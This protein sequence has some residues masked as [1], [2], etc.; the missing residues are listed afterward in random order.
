MSQDKNNQNNSERTDYSSKKDAVERL[1][2]AKNKTYTN[3]QG[4]PGKQYRKGGLLS[5]IPSWIKAVFIKFWFSGAICY[6][7][8]W[9]L[10]NYLWDPLDMIVILGIVAGMVNDIL[11]NNAFRFFAIVPD[12]NNKWM[13][14]PKKKF[15]T[16]FANIIYSMVIMAI[17]VLIYAAINIIAN[18]IYGTEKL[19]YVGVEPLLFGIIYVA[20]D[21]LFIGIKTI[22]FRIVNDAK[23]KADNTK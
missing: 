22:F 9:G 21:M 4:D 3:T 13:M 5:K 6:F 2:N 11:V 14:F 15:W 8:Y 20:V 7:I 1:V 10:G 17:M 12:G 19:I 18:R 16:F 23:E